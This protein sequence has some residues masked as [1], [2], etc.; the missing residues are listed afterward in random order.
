VGIRGA[1]GN[2]DAVFDGP[3]NHEKPT[4]IAPK[5][6]STSA[7]FR[8]TPSGCTTCTATC[9]SG[10]RTAAKKQATSEH[11]S[12]ALPPRPD[13][14]TCECCAAVHGTTLRGSS[15]RLTAPGAFPTSATA[16]SG[17]GLPELYSSPPF[18]PRRGPDEQLKAMASFFVSPR[19]W[20]N[21]LRKGHRSPAFR[22]RRRSSGTCR[23]APQPA[24]RSCG[25]LDRART[26]L[27]RPA[28]SSD[29]SCA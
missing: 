10:S 20:I 12:M 9:R 22:S 1:G 28:T 19:R 18:A 26:A 6:R 14:A 25:E 11:R 29:W 8:P 16:S 27:S 5:P 13:I 15:A 7:P 24:G 4:S 2:D 17:S 23:W 21:T 3:D